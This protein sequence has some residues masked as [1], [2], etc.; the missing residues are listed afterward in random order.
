MKKILIIGIVVI[1]AV[2]I[3]CAVC[4]VY[5]KTLDSKEKKSFENGE[6]SLASQNYEDAVTAYEKALAKD[7]ENEEAFGIS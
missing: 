2:L 4:L 7:P 1:F 5:V 6:A 3:T